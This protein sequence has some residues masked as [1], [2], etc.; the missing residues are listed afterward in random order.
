MAAAKGIAGGFPCGVV[1]TVEKVAAVMTP[2]SHGTTFGGNPLAMAVADATLEVL[3]GDGFLANVERTGARLKDQLESLA[4]RHPGVI[5][6]VRGIGL[7]LGLKLQPAVTVA[8]FVAKALEEGLL[9][10]PAGDNVVRV[11]PPLIIGDGEIDEGMAILTRVTR[12]LS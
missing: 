5:A 9:T 2:G 3:L 11:L 8:A 1:L 7:L 4:A 10:V 12:A 6:E